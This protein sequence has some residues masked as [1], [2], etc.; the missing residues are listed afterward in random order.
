M[1]GLRPD[2]SCLAGCP[3][4]SRGTFLRTRAHEYEGCG[5]WTVRAKREF[6]L[7]GVGVVVA[8]LAAFY[9]F[10]LVRGLGATLGPR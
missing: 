2:E 4:S 10:S 7:R 1:S 3:C 8:L 9:I 5:A 6:L